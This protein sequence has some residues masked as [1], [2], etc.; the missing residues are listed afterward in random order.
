MKSYIQCSLYGSC[1]KGEFK[2]ISFLESVQLIPNLQLLGQNRNSAKFL[3]CSRWQICMGGNIY[4]KVLRAKLN[5][6]GYYDKIDRPRI[7]T[8]IDTPYKW[9]H[10]FIDPCLCLATQS[11]VKPL[12]PRPLF[13]NRAKWQENKWVCKS[14]NFNS[15]S[16]LDGLILCFKFKCKTNPLASNRFRWRFV[17]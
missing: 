2:I 12:P 7:S 3:R 11:K 1:I 10:Q 4:S 5:P 9:Y 15:R 16:R 17:Y 6:C 8:R 14:T 13:A